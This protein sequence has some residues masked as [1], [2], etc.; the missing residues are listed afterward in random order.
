[1]SK[2]KTETDILVGGQ[3]VLEGVMM[4]TPRAWAVA[5]RRPDG[6]IVVKGEKAPRWSERY[7]FLAWPFLRGTAVLIQSLVLGIRALNWSAEVGM[8]A[9]N[10]ESGKKPGS[11]KAAAAGT[12]VFS[13]LMGVAFFVLLPYWLSGLITV[14]ALGGGNMGDSIHRNW[15]FFNLVDGVIRLAFFL[16]YIVLI[17]FLKDIRR[18]FQYHGAEHKVVH[19]WEAK[20]A[21]T[22][23]GARPYTTLH[24]RCGTSFLLFVMAVSILVFTVFKFDWWVWKV[25]TRVVL[26][27]LVTGISYE[28]V[29]LSARFPRNI[30]FRSA[31]APGLALQRITTRPPSDDMLEVALRALEASLAIEKAEQD[32]KADAA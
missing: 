30:L 5:V 22:V 13:L 29:R 27:P 24:P 23:E 28:L 4:R 16:G 19:L 12:L 11:G 6:E 17:S 21:L 8:E 3:A 14:K 20:G 15:V 31:M 2:S 25:A 32:G 18:V 9:E 10:K 26:L 1:M 7:P